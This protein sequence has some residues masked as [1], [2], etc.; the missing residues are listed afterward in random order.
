[1]TPVN[2]ARH[3]NNPNMPFW[4][5]I[6]EG[7]DHF[8]VTQQEPKVDFCENKYVFDA[9]K[10]PNA[11]RDPVFDASAKCPA[12]VIP[13][14]IADAVREKQRA[15]R[16]QDRGADREGNAGGAEPSRHRR[17]HEPRVR[18]QVAGRQHRPVGR[19]R[20]PGPVL[21]AL[22]AG[23]RHHSA[24]TSI[25][26]T[27]RACEEPAVAATTPAP[28]TRVATAAPRPS[29]TDSSAASPARSDLAARRPIPPRARRRRRQR[30]RN[31][32][33]PGGPSRIRR[34]HTNPRPSRPPPGRR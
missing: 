2:M 18:R 23:T 32:S 27:R 30:S 10:P 20:R 14:E 9:A 11:T 29:L 24:R 19:R 26:R 12:Y 34:R 31:R 33:R 21:L 6:K 5:M 25:R 15:G 1:M 4:K 28:S 7:Y 8:E 17:R 16:R 3:R 22:F 13:D